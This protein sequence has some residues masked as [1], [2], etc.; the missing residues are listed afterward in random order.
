MTS[1][2]AQHPYQHPSADLGF[3]LGERNDFCWI[4]PPSILP[5]NLCRVTLPWRRSNSVVRVDTSRC[6][7]CR[8]ITSACCWL[9]GYRYVL[10]GTEARVNLNLQ[11]EFTVGIL[12]RVVDIRRFCS[13]TNG[14]CSWVCTSV[15]GVKILACC[16]CDTH[17][18]LQRDE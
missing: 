1:L 8:W 15:A 17:I 10:K 6:S 9:V 13:H 5:I 7:K 4:F 14:T 2:G 16:C 18:H 3:G 12:S 11:M